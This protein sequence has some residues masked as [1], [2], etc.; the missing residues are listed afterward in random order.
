MFDFTNMISSAISL[1][2]NNTQTP[3]PPPLPDAFGIGLNYD[4]TED[5]DGTTSTTGITAPSNNPSRPASTVPVQTPPPS[6]SSKPTSSLFRTQFLS[7]GQRRVH[8]YSVRPSTPRQSRSS[9]SSH[10]VPGPLHDWSCPTPPPQ[11]VRTPAHQRVTTPSPYQT[12]RSTVSAQTVGYSTPGTPGVPQFAPTPS[13]SILNSALAPSPIPTPSPLFTHQH[14]PRP[15]R[16]VTSQRLDRTVA[17]PPVNPWLT[18]RSAPSAAANH[19]PTPMP[20]PAP[21]F[22][23]SASTQTRQIA[24][25]P[26]V[27]VSTV[28][29]P[30]ISP[31]PQLPAPG[32]LFAPSHA[33]P[34]TAFG[35]WPATQSEPFVS[36][37]SGHSDS[38]RMLGQPNG[39][40]QVSTPSPS[41]EQVASAVQTVSQ[42]S[43][44][45]PLFLP[46]SP[47][48]C[49]PLTQVPNGH[50][51]VAYNTVLAAPTFPSDTPI[52]VFAP[53]MAP[54]VN[55]TATYV[56]PTGILATPP[57]ACIAPV[58]AQQPP[59]RQPAPMSYDVDNEIWAAAFG[60]PIT[61]T[62]FQRCES[63]LA[64][65][66][67]DKP[68]AGR[69]PRAKKTLPPGTK[70]AGGPGGPLKF[71]S[72]PDSYEEVAG[73]LSRWSHSED[74]TTSQDPK[75]RVEGDVHFSP[76]SPHSDNPFVSWVCTLEQ[77]TGVL[78]WVRFRAGQ[79]HPGYE[80][81]VFK[82]AQLPRTPPRWLKEAS[83]R[84]TQLS[85]LSE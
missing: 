39:L 33:V 35:S 60:M 74:G 32:G 10:G 52:S 85:Q 8:P 70:W 79:P 24:P 16:P 46:E 76:T 31:R 13:F 23:A 84:S 50:N 30:I 4:W 69:S 1:F 18:T 19:V 78:R 17:V 5:S 64:G 42:Y 29:L 73:R 80:G 77:H 12:P 58:A 47:P 65:E 57:P 56:A 72:K 38:A 55:A 62:G 63:V 66:S 44:Q 75:E 45:R 11:S 81:Y 48:L 36:R 7:S 26:V 37:N 22:I 2:N 61:D 71:N 59:L 40:F 68:K 54:P 28:T 51:E 14:Q 49:E 21:S 27:P 43:T 67:P 20:P 41:E 6:T 53:S 83:Y 15:S 9:A 34:D 3:V 82:P 25:S